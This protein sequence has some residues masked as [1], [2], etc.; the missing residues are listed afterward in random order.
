MIR[1]SDKK[2]STLKDI[3]VDA[4]NEQVFF[5]VY[6][7]V[8]GL[9]GNGQPFVRPKRLDH[10]SDPGWR[11][12]ADAQPRVLIR[13]YLA[14]SFPCSPAIVNGSSAVTRGVPSTVIG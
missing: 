1:T 7:C 3:A 9:S 4:T 2:R 12:A 14:G 8:Q 6:L 13:A 11:R 10:R 5:Q